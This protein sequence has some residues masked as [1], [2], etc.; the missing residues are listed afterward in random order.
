[1]KSVDITW[2]PGTARFT[3]HGASDTATTVEAPGEP[4]DVALDD[5]RHARRP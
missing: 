4:D 1:M 5:G 2:R 3:A